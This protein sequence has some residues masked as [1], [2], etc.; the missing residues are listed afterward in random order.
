MSPRTMLA[1]MPAALFI[2]MFIFQVSGFDSSITPDTGIEAGSPGV[3]FNLSINNTNSTLNMTRVNITLPQGF[4]FIN[5]SNQTSANDTF[6]QASPYPGWQ[7][8]T[9]QGIVA[10]LSEE[11]F[12]FNASVNTTPGSY[13]F[14]V[15]VLYVYAVALSAVDCRIVEYVILNGN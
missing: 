2:I 12:V 1:F 14:T 5:G 10:N 3:L 13:N 15:T 6:F 7:N 9:Q 4:S 11:W 8:T